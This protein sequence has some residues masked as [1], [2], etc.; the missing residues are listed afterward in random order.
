MFSKRFAFLFALGLTAAIASNGFA[1]NRPAGPVQG[2]QPTYGPQRPGTSQARGAIRQ[3]RN[4]GNPAGAARETAPM[5]PPKGFNLSPADQKVVDDMLNFWEQ[6]TSGI[7]TFK[8]TF[9]RW[10]YDP[11]FGPKDNAATFTTGEIRY[12]SPDRGMIKENQVYKYDAEMKKRGV[13]W[14]FAEQKDVIGEHWICDGK[15]VFEFSHKTKELVET[16]LPP[17]MQGKAIAEGPLPF[18]FGAKAATIKERYWIKQLPRNPQ[19][20]EPYH[21]EFIPKHRGADF[22]RVRIKLDSQRFLPTEMVLYDLNLKG[23]S[24][25]AF[26]D[27]QANGTSNTVKNFLGAFVSPRTP[28]GWRKTVIDVGS[29]AQQAQAPAAPKR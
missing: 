9:G 22:S 21:L 10:V 26:K 7:K 6:K 13:A 29:Q 17:D 23:R 19:K 20:N 3:A 28:R 8:A 5:G 2:P 14:P 11:V 1:Q 27:L 18:M 12:A 16:R 15:S 25:Y 4:T 24:A